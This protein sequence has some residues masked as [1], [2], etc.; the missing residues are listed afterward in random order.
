M[1]QS[2]SN[3]PPAPATQLRPGERIK[4]I[5]GSRT[6]GVVIL[7]LVILALILVAKAQGVTGNRLLSLTV[8]G[9]VLGAILSLGAIGLTLIFVVLAI[10]NFALGDLITGG[11]YLALLFV[12]FIP[13]A[14]S[15][16]PFWFD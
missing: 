11:A 6:A 12:A 10:P 9:V 1:N 16:E 14:N 4:R 7:L 3:T 5:L 13:M 2:V 15:I 8:R